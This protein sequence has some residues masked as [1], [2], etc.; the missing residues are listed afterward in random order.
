MFQI[1]GILSQFFTTGGTSLAIFA[2]FFQVQEGHLKLKKLFSPNFHA[3][4]IAQ[5]EHSVALLHLTKFCFQ[6][7]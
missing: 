6:M 4:M 1:L 5:E 2:H 3:L 7:Q